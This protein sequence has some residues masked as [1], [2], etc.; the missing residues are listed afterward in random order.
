ML[1]DKLLLKVFQSL[2]KVP[3]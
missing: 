2:K 1:L 3:S